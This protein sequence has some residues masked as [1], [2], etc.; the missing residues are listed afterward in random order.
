MFH[1]VW[2]VLLTCIL[3]LVQTV[4]ANWDRVCTPFTRSFGPHPRGICGRRIDETLELLCV[5]G[6]NEYPSTNSFFRKKR[7]TNKGMKW[8]TY[9]TVHD[10]IQ[11]F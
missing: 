9:V 11:H 10:I 8:L 1:D 4:S 2:L 6:Y 7:D 3:M 5:A